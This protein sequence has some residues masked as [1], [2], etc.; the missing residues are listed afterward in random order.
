MQDLGAAFSSATKVLPGKSP[1][2]YS[3]TFR[4]VIRKCLDDVIWDTSQAPTMSRALLWVPGSAVTQ[5]KPCPL[6]LGFWGKYTNYKQRAI[7]LRGDEWCEDKEG[8]GTIK[9]TAN[10]LGEARNQV[11]PLNNML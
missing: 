9:N 4:E 7:I 8:M 11:F 10:F 3:L 2:S 1:H 6:Q 5:T